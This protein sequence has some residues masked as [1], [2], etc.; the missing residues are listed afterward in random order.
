MNE[1]LSPQ[2]ADAAPLPSQ[3]RIPSLGSSIV[4]GAIGFTLL[5]IV[6]FMPWVLAGRFFYRTIGEVGLYV[7]CALVFI[8]LSAPLLH[9]LLHGERTYGRFYK[10]FG[11]AFTAYSVAWIAGWMVF[12]GHTGS[13]VGLFSGCVVMGLVLTAFFRAWPKLLAVIAIL[14]IANTVGYF[15]G[16]WIEGGIQVIRSGDATRDAISPQMASIIGKTLWGVLYGLGFGAGLGASF[17]L[18]QRSS[19]NDSPDVR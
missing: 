13:L 8:I 18:L 19:G 15:I 16:G 12:K 1:S 17:Y 2:R 4:R 6:G 10:I 3:E 7:V 11:V 5:S 14:F 9:R